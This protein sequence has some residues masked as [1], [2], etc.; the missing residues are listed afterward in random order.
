MGF[1]GSV[2]RKALVLAALQAGLVST[3]TPW[4]V[5]RAQEQLL[6]FNIPRG[7][8]GSVLTKIGSVAGKPV[9]FSAALTA[10]RVAGPIVGRKSLRAA[11]G[12]ALAGSGLALAAAGG[13]FTVVAR[14]GRA[15]AATGG[16]GAAGAAGDI[17]DIADI[18]VTGAGSH[19]DDGFAAGDSGPT[20]RID[21][22]IKEIPLSV[23]V[24]T[25]D[26]I[27]SENITNVEDAF[28]NVAGVTITPGAF[29]NPSFT[30]RG[31]DSGTQPT[32]N[33]ALGGGLAIVPIDD[34]DRV[35]VLKGPSS[36]L[37]G[38]S[39]QGGLVNVTT[40]QPTDETIRDVTV[41][42]GSYGY[43]TLAFDLGGRVPQT[44]G[45]TYRLNMSGNAASE[46][47]SGYSTPHEILISPSIKWQDKDSSVLLGVRYYDV[48]NGQTPQTTY[49]ANNQIIK[50]DLNHPQGG[51]QFTTVARDVDVYGEMSHNFGRIFGFDVS[52]HNRAQ[53]TEQDGEAHTAT[54]GYVTTGTNAI[55]YSGD[56]RYYY[57][58]LTERADITFKRDFGFG[59]SD[60]KYGFDFTDSGVLYDSN[61]QILIQRSI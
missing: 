58:I 15:T 23:S 53:Y 27:Q 51:P 7:D 48:K 38:N 6:E 49:D 44:E 20:T 1:R 39:Q 28:Q 56:F 60:S 61:M 3:I 24:V 13:G 41:R 47:Y 5:V 33:G 16:G 2:G 50:I 8:L 45:L 59:Q 43:K 36:I 54:L 31:F 10:G 12:E 32:V 34:I 40:K 55:F 37:T 46:T 30:I 14:P 11:F 9:A 57:P 26:V 35:E 42:L 17:A 29:G 19:G 18:D 25:N 22:P 52:V 21:G 4:S